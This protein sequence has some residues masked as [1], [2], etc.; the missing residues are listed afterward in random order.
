VDSVIGAHNQKTE[1]S[2]RSMRRNLSRGGVHKAKLDEHLCEFL[3]RRRA[4]KLKLDPFSLLLILKD[5]RKVYPG[6]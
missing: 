5:I 2:W 3:W 1:S 6:N 4:T